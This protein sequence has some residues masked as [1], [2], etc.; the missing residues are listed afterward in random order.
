RSGVRERR[1]TVA[2]VLGRVRRRRR[3]ARALARPEGPS[4]R[5]G[6][7]SPSE[8]RRVV[9]RAAR[10]VTPLA[11]VALV[12][13][14]VFAIGDWWSK[15]RNDRRLQDLCKAATMGARLL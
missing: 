6:A 8:R 2:G 7:L 14:F 15:A 12:A 9:P 13:T 4:P 11:T 1:P 5:S 10:A 3:R